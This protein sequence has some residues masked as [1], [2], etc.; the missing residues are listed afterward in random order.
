M[1]G[2]VSRLPK[3]L[4]SIIVNFSRI[5]ILQSSAATQLMCGEIFNNHFFANCPQYALIKKLKI[6]QI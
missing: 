2:S 5:Y 6:S 1:V 4:L 3:R